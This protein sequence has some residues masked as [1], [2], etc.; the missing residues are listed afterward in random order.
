MLLDNPFSTE[1]I[2]ESTPIPAGWYQANC[3]KAELC[4]TKAG[5]G[6]YIKTTFAIIGPSMQ[7]RCVFQN[8]NVKN[9]NTEAERIGHQQ[10]AALLRAIGKKGVR[11]TD[12]LLGTSCM[13]NVTIKPANDAY[14]E[15]NDIKGYKATEGAIPASIPKQAVIEG[16]VPANSPPPWVKQ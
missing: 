9:P 3:T 12:E 5:N 13:I 1:G 7:G 2:P 16:T 11:D 4:A 10:F 14:P 15:G 6:Q 8:F